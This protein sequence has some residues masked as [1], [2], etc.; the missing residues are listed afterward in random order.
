MTSSGYGSATTIGT[1]STHTIFWP[2]KPIMGGLVQ[3]KSETFVA[4]MGGTPNSN[5]TDLKISTAEPQ[6]SS[7]ICPILK[8]TP[9]SVSRAMVWIPSSQKKK[10]S[11]LVSNVNYSVTSKTWEW[12]PLPTSRIQEIPTRW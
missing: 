3:I 9:V 11:C 7:Q 4:W 5:W 2:T 8:M 6:Q 1:A 12:T 10:E